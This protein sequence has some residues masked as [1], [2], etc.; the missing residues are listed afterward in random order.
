MTAIEFS[1]LKIYNKM[2]PKTF[3][4]SHLKKYKTCHCKMLR[5]F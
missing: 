5:V 2:R 4:S 3:F 1:T